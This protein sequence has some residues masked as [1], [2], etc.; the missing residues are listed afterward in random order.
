[1]KS[2]RPVPRRHTTACLAV[3]CAAL[4]LA[5]GCASDSDVNSSTP[6]ATAEPTQPTP[7]PSTS[8]SEPAASE[9]DSSASANTEIEAA[10]PAP[11]A[12]DT[13]YL[14]MY[15][16]QG[17]LYDPFSPD[18]LGGDI[19]YAEAACTQAVNALASFGA[20]RGDV[21]AAGVLASL[22][23]INGTVP[24]NFAPALQ[25]WEQFIADHSDA[26]SGPY[27]PVS[28]GRLDDETL[29]RV[30]VDADVVTML[31]A[32]TSLELRPPN[33]YLGYLASSCTSV[34]IGTD[35]TTG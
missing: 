13:T 15:T 34:E 21:D 32:Y 30:L 25:A 10:D 7:D 19:A 3:A 31:D 8:G 26:Y 16:D 18:A 35:P 6:D 14:D 20:A 2:S 17:I 33:D 5:A 9:P 23:A 28:Q 1:M 27:F 12:V 22:Q 4:T 29:R 24:A 11:G